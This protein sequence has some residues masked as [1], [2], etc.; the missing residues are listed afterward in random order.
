[1]AVVVLSGS[2][3]SEWAYVLDR[4]RGFS[5]GNDLT[6]AVIEVTMLAGIV[7]FGGWWA[8]STYM[9]ERFRGYMGSSRFVK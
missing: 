8:D 9:R 1:V 5:I 3:L 2:K 4:Q 6:V 7:F